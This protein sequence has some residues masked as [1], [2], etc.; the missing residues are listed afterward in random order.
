MSI[1]ESELIEEYHCDMC[2]T[3][4]GPSIFKIVTEGATTGLTNKWKAMLITRKFR[5]HHFPKLK[6]KDV[7]LEYLRSTGF[8]EPILVGL[9]AN[10]QTKGLDMIMPAELLTVDNVRN[11]LGDN[12]PVT[13]IDVATQ[14]ELEQWTMRSWAEYFNTKN[15]SRLYNV[16]SLEVSKTALA[17]KI[18]IPH[19]VRELDWVG[20]F[21]PSDVKQGCPR[22]K[23]FCLMGVAGSFT[24]FHID[25][26]GSSVFYHIVSGSKVFYLA[27]PTPANLEVYKMWSKNPSLAEPCFLGDRFEKSCYKVVLK[28]G[29]TLY[30][31][32]ISFMGLHRRTDLAH[33]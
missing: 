11:V 16:I 26:G 20:N 22:V 13:V 24:N 25:F 32:L 29:D 2:A 14:S 21:W 30:D 15:R 31:V 19:I 10:G 27:E 7:T 6:G 33:H 5:R 8:R 4:A 12:M 17:Q 3:S 28:Q 18:R 23:L 1:Q 9:D